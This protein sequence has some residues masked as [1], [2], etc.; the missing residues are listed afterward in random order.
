[1]SKYRITNET[2][3]TVIIVD[4]LPEGV[5]VGVKDTGPW[6]NNM[7]PP[8]L[9][10]EEIE[11]EDGERFLLEDYAFTAALLRRH[12]ANKRDDLF[13]AVCSNN[14]NIILAALD[15]ASSEP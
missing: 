6:V 12:V 10:V 13:R 11:P 14:L 15:M 9:I 5:R 7:P 8:K 3:G 2:L 1:M 4:K